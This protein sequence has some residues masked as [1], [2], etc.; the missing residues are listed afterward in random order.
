MINSLQTNVPWAPAPAW[1]SALSDWPSHSDLLS[2]QFICDEGSANAIKQGHAPRDVILPPFCQP[3]LV[4]REAVISSHTA[5]LDITRVQGWKKVVL[6][7]A[8]PLLPPQGA[9]VM[10]P[11]LDPKFLLSYRDLLE[12]RGSMDLLA[13]R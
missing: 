3:P 9:S 4:G 1:P 2:H 10:L 8:P 7:T 11:R 5:Q 13:Q 6:L 12:S